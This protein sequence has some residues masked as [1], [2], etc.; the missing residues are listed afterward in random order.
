[1]PPGSTSRNH[2]SLLSIKSFKANLIKYLTDKLVDKA[3]TVTRLYPLL[4][5]DSPSMSTLLQISD[6][7]VTHHTPNKQGEADYARHHATHAPLSDVLI[8][9][10][11]TDSWVYGLGIMEMGWLQGKTV[12]VQR[13]ST[14][15]SDFVNINGLVSA[16]ITHEQLGKLVYPVS[17]IVTLYVL[18]GCDYVSSF[19]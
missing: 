16:I 13:G 12:Y 4:V 11:D 6:G 7:N 14:S 8:V 5:V 9:S 18:T 15:V 1:M 2:S 19:Y 10:S 17:S 3:V